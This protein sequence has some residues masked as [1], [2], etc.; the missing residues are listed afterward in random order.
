MSL[1]KNLCRKCL[2]RKKAIQVA[3]DEERR[4]I[5]G[6]LDMTDGVSYIML[7]REEMF[8][9]DWRRGQVNCSMT[10]DGAMTVSTMARVNENP[11]SWCPYSVEQILVEQP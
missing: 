11:P 1:N 8:D 3:Q 10:D 6:V 9:A 7:D 4:I 2:F 5:E